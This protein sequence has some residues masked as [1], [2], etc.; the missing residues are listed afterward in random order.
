MRYDVYVEKVNYNMTL[1][2]MLDSLPEQFIQDCIQA[3]KDL[4]E[5]VLTGDRKIFIEHDEYN[6]YG[7]CGIV[8][9]MVGC[10]C[11]TCYSRDIDSNFIVPLTLFA[12][13]FSSWEHF[14]GNEH[15]P[16]GGLE[17]FIKRGSL[18]EGVRGLRRLD[19]IDHLIESLDF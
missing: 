11:L 2:E 14:S 5:S 18:W 4:K 6:N 12:K 7:I 10:A 13:L 3:L 1:E 16:I 9:N 19:L 8:N 17:E 15:Y